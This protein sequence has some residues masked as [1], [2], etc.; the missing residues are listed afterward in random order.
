MSARR[1]KQKRGRRNLVIE[2]AKDAS[3]SVVQ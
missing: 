2:F 1:H 3:L